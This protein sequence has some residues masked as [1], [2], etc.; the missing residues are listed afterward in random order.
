MENV[1]LIVAYLAVGTVLSFSARRHLVY[2]DALALLLFWPFF[3]VLAFVKIAVLSVVKL[4]G[5]IV[6][7]VK[8]ARKK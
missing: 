7:V 3:S 1:L 6:L 5:E 8:K 4:P 2:D